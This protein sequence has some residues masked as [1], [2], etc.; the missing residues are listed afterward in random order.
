ML[1]FERMITIMDIILHTII[2]EKTKGGKGVENLVSAF[3]NNI[4]YL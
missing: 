3:R 1:I 4:F 2:N